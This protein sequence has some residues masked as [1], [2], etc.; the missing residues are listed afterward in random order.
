V[1]HCFYDCRFN[2]L[3]LIL[4]VFVFCCIAFSF[5]WSSGAVVRPALWSFGGSQRRKRHRCPRPNRKRAKRWRRQALP[6]GLVL[7]CRR[8]LRQRPPRMD[9]SF[10]LSSCSRKHTRWKKGR[11]RARNFFSFARITKF[12]NGLR[13][14]RRPYVDLTKPT[15]DG[16]CEGKDFLQV[17]RLLSTFRTLDHN[18]NVQSCLA[19][20]NA[21]HCFYGGTYQKSQC[22]HMD[23]PLDP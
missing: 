14:M 5:R 1:G 21:T 20:I 12:G 16:F 6:L 11:S 8:R 19:R 17:F 9:G 10:F 2:V 7:R 13:S 22:P 23:D 4:P 15:L 3:T 18:K